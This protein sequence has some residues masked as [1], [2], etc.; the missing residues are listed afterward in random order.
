M[1]FEDFEYK[2]PNYELMKAQMEELFG[3]LRKSS[4]AGEAIHYAVDIDKI[5]MEYHSMKDLSGLLFSIDLNNA[6][7]VEEN[8]YFDIYWPYFK[9]LDSKYYRE[10]LNSK[11]L[12]DFR[13]FYGDQFI[14]LI[15]CTLKVIDERILDDLQEEQRLVSGNFRTKTGA[16][17]E[18]RG[19]K[20]NLSTLSGYLDANDRQTRIDA[21]NAFYGFYESVEDDI[22]DT[23]DAL[24]KVRDRK[25][26]K[27][28]YSNFVEMGYNEMQRTDYNQEMVADFR[29]EVLKYMTPLAEKLIKR[30]MKR[31]HVDKLPYYDEIV[32]FASGNPRP[33]GTPGEI[34][35][36][37]RGMYE[38]LSPVT[39]EYFNYMLDTHLLDVEPRH[40]KEASGF[41][42]YIG[43]YRAPFLFAN[44]NGSFE[45][46]KLVTHEAGHAFQFYMSN[47]YDIYE[48]VQPTMEAAEVHSLSMEMFTLP[49]IDRFFAN[50]ADADKYRFMVLEAAVHKV[51]YTCVVDEFQ[52]MVYSNPTA[53][54][55]DRRKMW[56][57]LEKKYLPHRDY[58]GSEFL[59]SGTWWFQQGH[60]FFRP[61]YF[62]DYGLA[63]ICSFEFFARM[64]KNYK[65]AWH[66]YV[67]LC[68]LGGSRSFTNLLKVAKIASPF[69]K[70]A[71]KAVA[72]FIEGYLDG[73]DDASL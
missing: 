2:R 21:N 8:D 50:K 20:H 54:K 33:I 48:S 53:T 19:Q 70:G 65:D 60:P 42:Q 30:Q 11:F 31:L 29:N 39:G 36:T 38:D 3:G 1:L 10:I 13:G 43:T 49:Y 68:K 51:P 22:E 47:H 35:E 26:K 59:E 12:E 57:D 71:V 63:E 61:F 37:A 4:S 67:E 32:K 44:C 18:F 5:R 7:Y 66:D 69:E 16:V 73:I 41:E 14:K 64:S 62:I 9:E 58:T 45:D 24:V 17:I 27:L 40:G 23:F 56:R 46:I 28:G 72:E 25:A 15:T 52:H 34:L 55:A 6:S